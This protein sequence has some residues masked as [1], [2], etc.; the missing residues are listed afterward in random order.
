MLNVN[1]P[2]IFND[3]IEKWIIFKMTIILLCLVFVVVKTVIFY[4]SSRKFSVNRW[5]NLDLTLSFKCNFKITAEINNICGC[6]IMFT[7]ATF[8]TKNSDYTQSRKVTKE[9]DI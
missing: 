2:N 1:L 4:E 6:I 9:L 5:I 8:L 3:K 7:C